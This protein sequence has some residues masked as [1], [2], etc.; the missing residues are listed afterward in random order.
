MD[1]LIT[2]RHDIP[3]RVFSVLVEASVS[4][5]SIC[6]DNEH[7]IEVDA[8]LHEIEIDIE[9]GD[10]SDYD[11]DGDDGDEEEDGE[12]VR[13]YEEIR[14]MVKRRVGLHHGQLRE[15]ITILELALWNAMICS[16]VVD[17]QES[18]NEHRTSGGRCLEVVIKHV[19]TFL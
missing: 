14:D 13:Y 12:N 15:S 18:R 5:R 10:S 16:K 8:R 17:D 6:M 3:T 7:R 9:N 1:D 4:E 11:G 2:A 19:L